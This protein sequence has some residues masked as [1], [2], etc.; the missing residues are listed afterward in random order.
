MAK[1]TII[2][3]KWEKIKEGNT[4]GRD[5]VLYRLTDQEGLTYSIFGSL[6]SIANLKENDEV[7]IEYSVRQNGKFKNMHVTRLWKGG[8]TQHLK[9]PES[10]LNSPNSSD[11]G[12]STAKF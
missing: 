6:M 9:E 8:A 5:W 12:A 7:N 10:T 1:K 3:T 2:A 11:S 4:K